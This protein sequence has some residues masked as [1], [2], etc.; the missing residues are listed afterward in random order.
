[1]PDLVWFLI[2]RLFAALLVMLALS[3]AVYLIFYAI[4]ADPAHLACGKPCTPDRLEQARHFMQLDQSTMQQYLNFL[5]GIVAGRTFGDGA[6]AVHCN[7]PCFG[8]SFP[9]ARP[10]TTLITDRLPITA[11][12]ALG[13]AVLWLLIGVSLGVD[14]RAEPGSHPRPVGRRGRADRRLDRRRSCSGC[15]RSWSSGSG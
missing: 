1:M 10:V 15:W 14:R 2:R 11:S 7:A 4:P 9:L 13:A 6:A 8:Y 5:K 12:I 3:L